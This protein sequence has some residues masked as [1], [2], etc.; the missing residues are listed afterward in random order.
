MTLIVE[1]NINRTKSG[2]QLCSINA[3]FDLIERSPKLSQTKSILIVK[4]RIVKRHNCFG[5]VELKK[6]NYVSSLNFQIIIILTCF[7]I[8]LQQLG[9]VH[10]FVRSGW[11]IGA[12]A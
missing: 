10:D 4:E 6:F 2:Q 1:H 3:K 8:I 12:L 7:L 11:N 9:K 5:T